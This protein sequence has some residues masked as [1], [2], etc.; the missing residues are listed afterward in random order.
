MMAA[1]PWHVPTLV[2]LGGRLFGAWQAPPLLRDAAA[3]CSVAAA[4]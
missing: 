4:M 1:V 2:R 3:Q